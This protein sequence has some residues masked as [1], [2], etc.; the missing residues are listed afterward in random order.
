MN[1]RLARRYA[2]ALLSLARADGT[3]EAAGEE[4]ARTAAIFEEPRLRAVLLSP[5]ID[6]DRRR[7]LASEVVDSL[8]ASAIVGNLLRLLAD[9]DRIGVVGDVARSYESLVDQELGRIRIVIRSAV[10]LGPA[11]RDAIIELARRL[12]GRQ[13][14]IPTT[15]VDTDLLGGVVL[16][17]AGTV[18]D[19]SVKT[20]LLRL[21]REMAAR[22]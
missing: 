3:L 5:A 9:H 21:S 13:N 7:K 16:D 6:I 15:E 17:V 4:L 20:Q 12:T 1:G 22:S 10:P 11:E 18:Y 14:I 19:G 2:R 8:N